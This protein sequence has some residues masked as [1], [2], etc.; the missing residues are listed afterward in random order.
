MPYRGEWKYQIESDVG[1]LK[2]QSF[3]NFMYSDRLED[4][5]VKLEYRDKRERDPFPSSSKAVFFCLSLSFIFLWGSPIF[6][7]FGLT[8]FGLTSLAS[9]VLWAF[10]SLTI[11]NIIKFMKENK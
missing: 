6:F 4:R 7:Y 10:L 2:Q 9:F 11:E 5:I 3:D 1:K 8:S